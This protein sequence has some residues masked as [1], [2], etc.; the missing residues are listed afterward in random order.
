MAK[1]MRKFLPAVIILLIA[2]AMVGTSTYA[3]FS[4]NNKVNVT[5]MTVTAT[6]DQ[7]LLIAGDTLDST[8]RK[9]DASF[10][11]TLVQPIS[12]TLKPVSSTDGKTFYY[13]HKQNVKGN[14]DAMNDVYTA[15]DRDTLSNATAFNNNYNSVG[16]VGYVDYVFQLKA[17]NLSTDAEIRLTKLD[18]TYG[19]S[20]MKVTVGGQEIDTKAFRVAVFYEDVSDGTSV[21]TLNNAAVKTLA[22]FKPEGADNFD[23]NK[24]V[25][26][27]TALSAVSYCSND[28]TA[29]IAIGEGETK[30]YKFLVRLWLEGEDKTCRND[31][32][33]RLNDKWVLDIEFNQLSVVEPA[34]S[35]IY[36]NQKTTAAASKTDIST[37]AKI[38]DEG[39]VKI[40]DVTYYPIYKTDDS[41]S[42]T[43]KEK[44][45]YVAASTPIT[46]DSK[47]Y[48]IPDDDKMYVTDV[49]NQVKITPPQV[50]SSVES[51]AVKVTLTDGKLS[52]GKVPAKY[53]WKKDGETVVEDGAYQFV[54]E[55]AGDY[56][57][58]I[59]DE[60]DYVYKTASYAF[61]NAVCSLETGTLS[62]VYYEAD[63]YSWKKVSDGSE[64]GSSRTLVSP[65]AGDYYCEIVKGA[66]TFSTI[67]LSVID[68][69][70]DGAEGTVKLTAGKLS[71]GKTP[72]GE[73]AYEWKKD[74]GA[75]V[76]DEKEFTAT[77]T[78]D[79][80]CL[81]TATDGNVYRTENVHLVVPEP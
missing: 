21:G 32:F 44:Q 58:L 38:R 45:L 68:A 59:T 51:A 63:S 52:N 25:G 69:D 31:A 35:V 54:P 10:G 11:N 62:A 60:N 3:W 65:V 57:C 50:A 72:A 27:A 43:Y 29:K 33:A 26:S 42:L 79:Y 5:G 18:L 64:V 75:V 19:G 1:S 7:N 55:Q 37:E 8:A 4:M 67:A 17:V 34:N 74:S 77:V 23:G 73:N 9:D 14:G 30:Y 70:V 13:T 39:K 53:T 48:I 41:A 49:T 81:I 24:A 12:G 20:S 66:D 16:A 2:A 46:P 28:Y 40:N 61:K 56:Y 47:I 80:Y 76:G 6:V 36:L 71:N 22:I 78:G 15:Y